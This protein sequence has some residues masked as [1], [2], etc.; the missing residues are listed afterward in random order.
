[1]SAV[2]VD[3]G[4]EREVVSVPIPPLR[5]APVTRTKDDLRSVGERELDLDDGVVAAFL[6]AQSGAGFLLSH[7]RKQ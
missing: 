7:G 2:Q 3:E 4:I 6:A 1:M 5:L